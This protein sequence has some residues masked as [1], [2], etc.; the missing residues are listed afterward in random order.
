M[1]RI[2]IRLNEQRD[3]DVIEWLDGQENKSEAIRK[4]VRDQISMEQHLND[5]L[6]E[7]SSMGKDP[8]PVDPLEQ[9]IKDVKICVDIY[10]DQ[11]HS[12]NDVKRF[13]GWLY[14]GEKK[15]LLDQAWQQ[16]YGVE[17]VE[18]SSIYGEEHNDESDS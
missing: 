5:M 10:K 16:V 13:I 8:D 9:A 18:L 17:K 3:R 4:A 11:V 12:V 15:Q 7:M 2:I 6:N 14:P 1:S